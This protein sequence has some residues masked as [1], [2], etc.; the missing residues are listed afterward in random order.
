MDLIEIDGAYGEGGG[1]VLRTALALSCLLQIP[2]RI[3]N[4]RANRRNPGLRPQ[5]LAS[6]KAAQQISNALVE[7]DRIGSR[8]LVFRPAGL[9]GGKYYFDIGQEQGSAGSVSLV[10]QT[11]LLP[12]IFAGERSCLTIK[13]GTHVPWSPPY[14]YIDTVFLAALREMGLSAEGELERWGWYPRGEGIVHFAIEP[15]SAASPII[16][17]KMGDLQRVEAISAVSNLPDHILDRQKKQVLKRLT[18]EGIK[19]SCTEIRAPSTGQGTFVFLNA[20]GS[21]WVSGFSSLGARGKRAE[22]VANDASDEF[23]AFLS[24][25]SPVDE[26]LADQLVPYMASATGKSRIVVSRITPH[27]LTNIWITEQ[28][29]NARFEVQG[30]LG[31]KGSVICCRT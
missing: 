9:K 19:G 12:L 11:V 25:S 14:H 21:N 22:E 31:E 23:F 2:F 5:H 26:H 29:S 4:I 17:D 16:R 6:V 15:V 20:V 8:S 13:G 28:F 10:F 24:A 30:E 3:D 7:G 27:L 1:Q 18:N